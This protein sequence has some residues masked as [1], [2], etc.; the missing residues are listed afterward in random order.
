MTSKARTLF[1][2]LAAGSRQSWSGL[3]SPALLPAGRD[4]RCDA[5]LPRVV[6]KATGDG[7][8]LHNSL[9]HFELWDHKEVLPHGVYLGDTLTS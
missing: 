8:C 5:P 9:L 2:E 3:S 4:E 7:S 1:C 6:G